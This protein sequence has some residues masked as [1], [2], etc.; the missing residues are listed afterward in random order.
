MIFEL[1]INDFKQIIMVTTR[2]KQQDLIELPNYEEPIIVSCSEIYS[3]LNHD[4][5]SCIMETKY[6]TCD[7]FQEKKKKIMFNLSENSRELSK[8][9]LFKI[10]PLI[11][12]AS[13]R[14][15][16]GWEN[17]KIDR[18]CL[19]LHKYY[20]LNKQSHVEG[21]ID[22]LYHRDLWSSEFLNIS[23]HFSSDRDYAVLYFCKDVNKIES[24]H[25]TKAMAQ[26]YY[27]GK[28]YSM[29]VETSKIIF[30]DKSNFKVVE[31]SKE[32]VTLIQNLLSD[33]RKAKKIG[34][35]IDLKDLDNPKYFPNMK[36]QDSLFGSIKKQYA[37]D[38][39]EI[40]SLWWCSDLNR[41]KMIEKG[42]YN[43]RDKRFTAELLST[44]DSRWKNTNK[45]QILNR[46]L[47]TNRQDPSSTD[48]KWMQFSDD[49]QPVL[50]KNSIYI[51]FE[52]ISTMN[53][54]L[55]MIGV[56]IPESGIP[57]SGLPESGYKVFWAKEITLEAEKELLME[58]Y[59][60]Y[61]QLQDTTIWYWYAEKSKWQKRCHIHQL[62][63][64]AKSADLWED[65]CELMTNGVSVYGATNY[66][67][68]SVTK[69]FSEQSKI[70][71]SY[72]DL[73]CQDGLESMEFAMNY[74][75]T[76]KEE[77]RISLEKYN[78]L[79]CEAQFH[80]LQTILETYFG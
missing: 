69:A 64:E 38:C 57:E 58:F 34:S 5:F 26:L 62:N 66:K 28:M 45:Q 59:T 54:I 40:T 42:I 41:Q 49:F 55:Y 20:F 18:F 46:I 44:V 30:V 15:Y 11:Q 70:P 22:A 72:S 14:P 39:G 67:L 37:F 74:Y 71:F 68:K 25:K 27:F 31:M 33:I 61:S 1:K 60:F 13:L 6:K 4:L 56:Y 8:F 52:Y 29:F 9:F 23:E 75:K 2:S 48:F 35:L 53:D 17:S 24:Y 51:D 36:I 16:L 77:D 21:V 78:Q 73:D 63:I 12:N 43:W 7:E 47:E 19:Y 10:N 80:I 76:R 3:A 32:D 50:A 65:L 79:D